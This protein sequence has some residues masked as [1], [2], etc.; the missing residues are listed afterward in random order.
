[1][2]G[3]KKIKKL[4]EFEGG[5]ID[6]KLEEVID[7]TSFNGLFYEWLWAIKIIKIIKSN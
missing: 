7:E 4:Q 5:R 3:Y 2:A 1:M 6:Q